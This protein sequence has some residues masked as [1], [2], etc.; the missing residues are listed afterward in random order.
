MI[1]VW[2]SNVST[3]GSPAPRSCPSRKP[4][5]CSGA[6]SGS[7]PRATDPRRDQRALSRARR[8]PADICA[9]CA[10]ANPSG[11]SRCRPIHQRRT[12]ST[13]AT[14]TTTRTA[15]ATTAVPSAGYFAPS[16][17]GF[18]VMMPRSVT[19]IPATG[20]P[21]VITNARCHARNRPP[22]A[23]PTISHAHCLGFS[24]GSRCRA[25]PICT[26]V[27]PT[28]TTHAALPPPVA[29]TPSRNLFR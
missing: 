22:M 27:L 9:A 11:L 5:S 13:P 29:G 17:N 3:T 12:S 6:V 28:G 14:P 16:D 15:H 23:A 2:S 21:A 1:P 25:R 24:S 20:T 19:P 8:S 26:S 10:D 4:T 7:N 18:A